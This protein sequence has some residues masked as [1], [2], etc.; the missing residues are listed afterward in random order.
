MNR[1]Q[2]G[3]IQGNNPHTRTIFAHYF[4]THFNLTFAT[5]SVECGKI[6]IRVV[7]NMQLILRSGV[8]VCSGAKSQPSTIHGNRDRKLLGHCTC[9]TVRYDNNERKETKITATATM[10]KSIATKVQK[11]EAMLMLS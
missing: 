10:I 8:Y 6:V 5:R 9:T 2:G 7:N 11:K 4:K 3:I 1:M